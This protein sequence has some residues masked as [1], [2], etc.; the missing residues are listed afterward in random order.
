MLDPL[1]KYL[2]NRHVSSGPGGRNFHRYTNI[3]S[4][5]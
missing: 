3:S 5:F 2:K 4:S 1:V